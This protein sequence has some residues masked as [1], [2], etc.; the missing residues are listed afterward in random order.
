MSSRTVRRSHTLVALVALA[1]ALSACGGGGSGGSPPPPPPPPASM[2]ITAVTPSSG[3]AAGAYD[4]TID[5]TGFGA[6]TSVRFGTAAAA[7]VTV[8]SSTRLVAV[9]PAHAAGMVDVEAV[10]AGG[11]TVLD[12]SAFRFVDPPAL[13]FLDPGHL[14]QAGGTVILHGSGFV[15]GARVLF[16]AD[17]SVGPAQWVAADQLVAVAPAHAAGAVDVAVVNPDGQR[18]A[19]PASLVFDAPPPPPPPPPVSP[20][21]LSSLAPATGP[22]TGGTVVTL[23]GSSFSAQATATFGG[24]PATVTAASVTSLTVVAP[25]HAPGAVEV[26]VAN[27]DGQ[28]SALAGAYAYVAVPAPAPSI[29]SIAP[30]SGPAAGG[31]AVTVSGASFQQGATV[32]VGGVAATVGTITASAIAIVTPAHAAGAADVSVTNPDGQK[33]SLAA[34]FTFLAPPPPPPPAPSIASIAPT[35][36]PIAGGTA[37]AIAGANFQAGATVSVGGVA[38][39]VGSVT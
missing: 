39:T 21:V 4:V 22:E 38:A 25:P 9:A 23:T 18:A 31:T 29:A 20:P 24:S 13:T 19:L 1:A 30:T 36:G 11:E 26:A 17:A 15:D 5:G 7:S 32:T 2:T 35:S 8:V 12:P 28:R 6:G 14:P 10:G 16:G 34:A 3:P 37:V 33:A 27:P